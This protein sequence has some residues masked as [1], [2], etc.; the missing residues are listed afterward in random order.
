MSLIKPS[1]P[2][3]T[4]DFLPEQMFRR[5]YVIDTVRDIFEKYGY[6]PLESPSIE[7]LDVLSGK[8]GDEGEQ[9]I[10]RVLKRGTGLEELLQGRQQFVVKQ[11]G[12]LVEEA[13][14]YD[15]TVP[16]SRVV[17]MYQNELIFPFKRY[18]IQPVWRADR[19]QRGRYREFYQCDVDTVGTESMLADAETIAIVYEV[20]ATLG[21]DKFKIRINNRKILNGIL[22]YAGVHPEKGD[23]VFIAID[24][25][26]R[27][28][29]DGVKKELAQNGLSE[30][31]TKKILTVLEISGESEQILSE[32]S[33]SFAQFETLMEGTEELTEV[34]QYLNELSVPRA[35]YKI[36]LYLVRGLGYYTGP[37]HESLVEEPKIGSLTGGGRYDQLVGM[38]LGRDIPATGT[39]FGIERIIDVMTQL[40]MFPESKTKTEVLVTIFDD[41]TRKASL[42]FTQELR[43]SGVNAEFFMSATKI[44][45]QLSYANKKR[46]PFV[47]I[48]GPDE[49]ASNEVTIKNMTTGEQKVVSREKAIEI[50]TQIR[51]T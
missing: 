48:I 41:S 11:Y 50:L 40:E 22:R 1:L 33:S 17:A 14:R 32:L 15:L 35:N 25:L 24:K 18:Q 2:K 23:S 43:K 34:I 49:I 28:G 7:K 12:E 46:I 27:I 20:L 21:F 51:K 5:Q 19:P 10:F 8:Y 42:Q 4:R 13:L 29:L 3:G 36:D 30:D 6:E 44:K 26:D 37:I 16:L 9:L 31:E 47:A 38:F 39:A 45:K